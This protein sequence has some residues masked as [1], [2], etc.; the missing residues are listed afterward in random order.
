MADSQDDEGDTGPRIDRL[1]YCRDD[2]ARPLAHAHTSLQ[3]RNISSTGSV[4]ERAAEA[5]ALR[6]SA[7]RR[8]SLARYSGL[9]WAVT[10]W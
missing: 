1:D 3:T 5:L 9:V 7:A 8:K 4:F 2:P 6:E 10:T